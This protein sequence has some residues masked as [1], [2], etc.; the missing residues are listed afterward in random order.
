MDR[1]SHSSYWKLTMNQWLTGV[2][3]EI[4]SESAHPSTINLDMT[5]SSWK[6]MR[7]DIF[8]HD[9]CISLVLQSTPK[10]ISQHWFYQ[11]TSPLHPIFEQGI[12]TFDLRM[13]VP[14]NELSLS[15]SQWNQLYRE[16]CLLRTLVQSMEMS[17]LLLM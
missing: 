10:I 8:L 12:V 5:A 2:Q 1:S 17:I 6:L 14:A 3:H 9:C 13:S 16:L 4:F 11:W 7:A 15:L